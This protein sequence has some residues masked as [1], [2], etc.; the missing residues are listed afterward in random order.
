MATLSKIDTNST[1]N[2]ATITAKKDVKSAAPA[3]VTACGNTSS[4]PSQ[5]W[6][7]SIDSDQLAYKPIVGFDA[8]FKRLCDVLIGGAAFII[9]MPL[10]ILIS[11]LIKLDSTG[12][13][14]FYQQRSGRNREP[15]KVYKFR[16]MYQ[17]YSTP[18][19]TEKSFIQ[20]QKNDPRITRIGAFLRRTSLDELPQLLNILQ[21]SMSLVGPRPHPAPLDEQ[22]SQIIPAINSR[23]TVKPGLTGW[24]QVNG[25]RGETLRVEDMVSRVEHDC[26]YI[27]NWSLWLD[28]KIIALTAIRGWTQDNAY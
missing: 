19:P 5:D 24:A 11:I 12:P 3:V 20:T 22:Y 15:I 10:F 18:V 2:V 6:H 25:F 28:I 13:A 17:N 8:A 26:H 7:T 1:K 4:A 14:L 27:K 21:G 23:Y 9:L 16:T